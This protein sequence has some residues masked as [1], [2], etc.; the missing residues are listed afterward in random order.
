MKTKEIGDFL[1][2]R[3][4][5][6]FILQQKL[7]LLHQSALRA[8]SRAALFVGLAWGVPL[9]LA[10]AE[11]TAWGTFD[12]GPYLLDLRVW[13]RYF[14]AIG[15]FILIEPRLERTLNKHLQQFARA[16]LL[17][18]G[19]FEAAA[20]AVSKA[21]GRCDNRL[22]EALFALVAF[23]ISIILYLRLLDSGQPLWGVQAS[24]QGN[25][26]S[27]VGWWLVAVSNPLFIFLVLRALWRLA[28]WSLLLRELASLDLRLVATH[29]DGQAG[30]AFLGQYPNAYV[31]FVFAISCVLGSVIAHELL[32]NSISVTTYGYLMA[33]WLLFVLLLFSLP[34]SA[35]HG[36][37]KDLKERTLQLCSSQATRHH[38][39]V[40]RELLGIN[41][42]AVDDAEHTA[43]EQIADPSKMLL[44]VRKL[45]TFLFSREAL[46]PIS[47]AALLPLVAAGAT[48]LPFKEIFKIMKK[49]L[50]V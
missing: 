12:K 27:A 15:L 24:P 46:L 23:T 32:E 16:P 47:A 28:V 34:L 41:V 10:I 14:I 20:R 3:G 7:G 19:S 9:I 18:P 42:T 50:L 26:L 40:E 4:G 33:S 39:A 17:A 5:P 36:R 1:A 6:F 29:P 49:L 11:G 30:L 35:F 25:S 48:Q 45:S 37:L 2:A 13:A 31:L 22:A 43:A 8:K 44:S 38:R 21:L